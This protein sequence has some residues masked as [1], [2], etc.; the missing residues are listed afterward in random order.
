MLRWRLLFCS[1]FTV[2]FK[3]AGADDEDII[4]KTLVYY[5]FAILN[6]IIVKVLLS[7]DS[8]SQVCSVSRGRVMIKV[9]VPSPIK[10]DKIMLSIRMSRW[11]DSLVRLLLPSHKLSSLLG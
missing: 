1:H 4:S 9:V 5:I 8:G 11:L 2:S 7:T 3:T 6:I 10:D